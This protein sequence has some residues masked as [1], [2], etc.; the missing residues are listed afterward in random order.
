MDANKSRK[1]PLVVRAERSAGSVWAIHIIQFTD[2]LFKTTCS[3]VNAATR[4]GNNSIIYLW[5]ACVCVHACERWKL[6]PNQ[7]KKNSALFRYEFAYGEFELWNTFTHFAWTLL[8]FS[9][10]LISMRSFH[11]HSWNSVDIACLM[12]ITGC[13]IALIR[14][15]DWFFSLSFSLFPLYLSPGACFFLLFQPS[16]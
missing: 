16:T 14:N 3:F 2:S 8:S 4:S 5:L 15:V 7:R 6:M 12:M 13:F 11:W 1:L 9:L 10:S